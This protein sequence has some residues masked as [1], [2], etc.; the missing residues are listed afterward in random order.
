MYEL[1]GV[2]K[3]GFD[4]RYSRWRELVHPDDLPRARAEEQAAIDE[5]RAMHTRFRVVRPDGQIRHLE[6]Y[7]EIKRADNDRVLGLVGVDRDV[8]DW[9]EAEQRLKQSEANLALAQEIARLGS[10][11][12]DLSSQSATWSAQMYRVL[13]CEPGQVMPSIE[14]LLELLHPEDRPRLVKAMEAA[15]DSATP[16]QVE[17]RSDPGRGSLRYFRNHLEKIEGDSDSAPKLVGT[18]TDI[19]VRKLEEMERERLLEQIQAQAEQMSQIMW[20]VPEGVVLIDTKGQVIVAN[21]QAEGY[22]AELA[23]IGDEQQITHLG[24]R[25]LATILTSPPAGSWHEIQTAGNV[26]EAD[27]SPRRLWRIA[28]R[29]GDRTSQCD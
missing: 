28:D 7:A 23:Q 12:Y 16:L 18:V 25:P 3:T 15:L 14:S 9:V 2:A 22:L 20:S 29:L 21:R 10:W 13:D 5:R 17:V 1:Y 8:T 6:T 24:E 11:E 27:R 19:T 4:P 26:Y